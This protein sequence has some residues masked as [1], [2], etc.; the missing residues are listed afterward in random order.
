MRSIP[1]AEF[2]A[3]ARTDVP[4]LLAE[5]QRL[6][7]ELAEAEAVVSDVTEQLTGR[8]LMAA[9]LV[10]LRAQRQAVLDLCVNGGDWKDDGCYWLRA[11]AVLVALGASS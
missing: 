1:D 2:I 6:R 11:D 10:V 7:G 3:A 9:E 4:A 8:A 5:V